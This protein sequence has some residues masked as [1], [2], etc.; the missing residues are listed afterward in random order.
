VILTTG[1]SCIADYADRLDAV[2]HTVEEESIIVSVQLFLGASLILSY[3]IYNAVFVIFRINIV[4]LLLNYLHLSL[5]VLYVYI[6]VCVHDTS[7][8]TRALV[9]ISTKFSYIK[10]F[11]DLGTANMDIYFSI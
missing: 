4:H 11:I 10:L 2:S 9:L 5:V 1:R 3:I 7:A 8:R 6:R